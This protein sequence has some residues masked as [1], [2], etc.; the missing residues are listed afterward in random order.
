MPLDGLFAASQ[1]DPSRALAEL[2]DQLLH[3]Q[4]A[5]VV[6]LV[7]LDVGFEFHHSAQRIARAERTG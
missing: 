3:P 6:L 2:G 1:R 5:A 7:A 4:S